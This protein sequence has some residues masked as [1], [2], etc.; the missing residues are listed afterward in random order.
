VADV[1]SL[2]FKLTNP[3]GQLFLTTL[4]Y[5]S[6]WPLIELLLDRFVLVATLDEAQHVTHFTQRTLSA[7]CER[8]GWRVGHIGNFQWISAISRADF[9]PPRARFRRSRVSG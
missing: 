2:F 1:L 7:M 8:A 3:G 9:S 4:N 6:A 5:Q